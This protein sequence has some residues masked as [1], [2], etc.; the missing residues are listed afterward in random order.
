MLALVSPEYQ[1]YDSDLH[2]SWRS[3]VK[4]TWRFLHQHYGFL[5]HGTF[6]TETLI[7]LDPKCN[8]REFKRLIQATIHFE[9]VLDTILSNHNHSTETTAPA[10]HPSYWR[11]S[12]ELANKSRHE[13]ILH[14]ENIANLQELLHLRGILGTAN[15]WS[16][17]IQSNYYCPSEVFRNAP[18]IRTADDLVQWG[19]FAMSFVEASLSCT[20][21]RLLRFPAD[22]IGLNRFLR[23]RGRGTEA[24]YDGHARLTRM[25]HGLSSGGAHPP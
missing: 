13:A 4:A 9:P 6:T 15:S 17:S 24:L 19:E 7:H 12:P 20:L 23:G 21:P 1:F 22:Q 8:L 14:I 16:T 2:S 11:T 5:G 18:Q 25:F 3:D 10:H